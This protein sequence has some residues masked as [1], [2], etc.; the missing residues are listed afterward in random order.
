[1]ALS[2]YILLELRVE[3]RNNNKAELSRCVRVP[4]S[5]MLKL[6]VCNPAHLTSGAAT[7]ATWIG[8]IG[9]VQAYWITPLLIVLLLIGLG[10]VAMNLAASMRAY[11][12]TWHSLQMQAFRREARGRKRDFRDSLWLRK[13]PETCSK[14]GARVA[15]REFARQQRVEHALR[16][17]VS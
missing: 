11:Q 14:T 5:T 3:M 12:R 8:L 1:M 13:H 10:A 6:V 16:L 4:L 2:Y 9:L 15:I 7:V 17:R